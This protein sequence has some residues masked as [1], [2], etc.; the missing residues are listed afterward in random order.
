MTFNDIRSALVTVDP[1]F[2]M[3]DISVLF[4]ASKKRHDTQLSMTID[5]GYKNHLEPERTKYCF[6]GVFGFVH[7]EEC[8]VVALLANESTGPQL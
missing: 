2:D 5:A 8:L 4:P 1:Y 6:K 7:A 3:S